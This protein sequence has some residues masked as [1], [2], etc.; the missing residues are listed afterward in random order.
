MIKSKKSARQEYEN[1]LYLEEPNVTFAWVIKK[2]Q[3]GTQY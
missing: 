1:I 3:Q 2:K